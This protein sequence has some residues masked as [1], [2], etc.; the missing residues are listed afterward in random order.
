MAVIDG[1]SGNNTLNGTSDADTIN[2]YDGDDTINGGTRPVDGNGDVVNGGN[3][4]DTLIVDASGESQSVSLGVG[5]APTYFVRSA[6]NHFFVD[7]YDVEKVQFTGGSGD[8]TINTGAGG[9]SVQGGGGIDY[10]LADYHT[11]TAAIDFKLGATGSLGVVGLSSIGGIERIALT[12]GSATIPSP[13]ARR[14]IP[15][16]PMTVVTLSI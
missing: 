7:A 14:Q 1:D 8:D 2:G 16:S 10:W 11:A 13:A 5:G 15:L 9:V 4:I 3:G 6:S 12:T